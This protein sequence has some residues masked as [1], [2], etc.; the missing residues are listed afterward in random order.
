MKGNNGEEIKRK[1]E[2]EFFL[3]N[4]FQ[5]SIDVNG[6]VTLL[7]SLELHGDKERREKESEGTKETKT[8]Q[9]VANSLLPKEGD[10]FG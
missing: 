5:D 8:K 6:E 2:E 7:G 1:E 9:N 3:M 10:R 4:L